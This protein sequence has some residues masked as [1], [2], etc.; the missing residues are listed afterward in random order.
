MRLTALRGTIGDWTYYVS[1]MTFMQVADHIRKI[2]DELH[3]SRSLSDMLQRNITDNVESIKQYLFSQDERFFDSLVLGIYDNSP[4]WIELE[5]DFPDSDDKFY[6][7]GFLEFSGNEKIFPIDGQHR[8]EGIKEAL[9]ENSSR[10]ES[11]KIVAIYVAH[12]ATDEGMKRSRRLFT[13][14]NRYAKPVTLTDIIS[15]DEDDAAAICSRYLIEDFS[16]F[17]DN[18]IST[19]GNKAIYDDDKKSFTSV[20]TLYNCNLWILQ[21]ILNE[22]RNLTTSTIRMEF[23]DSDDYNRVLSNND[24]L[25]KYLNKRRI[26][27]SYLKNYFSRVRPSN[28]NLLNIKSQIFEFWDNFINNFGFLK[29]YLEDTSDQSATPYR[30]SK[31]GGNL[32]FRP[33]GLE[34]FMKAIIYLKLEKEIEYEQSLSYFDK[35]EFGLESE[36]WSGV[37]WNPNQKTMVTGVTNLVRDL[38]IYAYLREDSTQEFRKKLADKL[39]DKR[40]IDIDEANRVLVEHFKAPTTS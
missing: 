16:L 28:D 21:V 22:N 38:F 23:D 36:L 9:K 30:N 2:D 37:L 18:R 15:L 34:A 11:D 6:D 25:T 7:L 39:S 24:L 32:L 4:T 13:T 17:K 1:I 12:K 20:I 40:G 19:K 33:I 27:I 31:I 8:V 10:F 3:R 35:F 29:N 5:L 14:L 26:T